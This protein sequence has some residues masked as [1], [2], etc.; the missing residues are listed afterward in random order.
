MLMNEINIKF[1]DSEASLCVF[2]PVLLFFPSDQQ[3]ILIDYQA[4]DLIDQY[5][6]Y[7]NIIYHLR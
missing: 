5:S 3:Y 7:L 2:P 6:T 4:D 1:F